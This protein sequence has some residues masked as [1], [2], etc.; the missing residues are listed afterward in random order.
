MDGGTAAV[1][2]AAIAG[3]R[4]SQIENRGGE[5]GVHFPPTAACRVSARSK[6]GK[7]TSEI[8]SIK[9][10]PDGTSADGSLGT[11]GKSVITIEADGNIHL[12]GGGAAGGA[13]AKP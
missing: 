2:F 8:A 3:D 7:I 5:I 12:S 4:D 10:T 1:S 9:T 13:V 6:A 11:A